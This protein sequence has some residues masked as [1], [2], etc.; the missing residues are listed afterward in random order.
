MGWNKD[1]DHLSITIMVKTLNMGEITFIA[2]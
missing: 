2:N 1:R